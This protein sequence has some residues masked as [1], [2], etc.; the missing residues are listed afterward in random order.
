MQVGRV[1]DGT[2]SRQGSKALGTSCSGAA[3]QQGWVGGHGAGQQR[4]RAAG[5]GA[6]HGLGAAAGRHS[7]QCDALHRKPSLLP[8]QPHA[9]VFVD[10]SSLSAG[11]AGVQTELRTAMAP[12]GDIANLLGGDGGALDVILNAANGLLC[13]NAG[14]K[15]SD[16][17]GMIDGSGSVDAKQCRCH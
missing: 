4:G 14:I 10:G 11:L 15:L 5:G 8:P 13:S 6:Q 2:R 3:G 9:A 12:G 16:I 7:L 1:V 17:S